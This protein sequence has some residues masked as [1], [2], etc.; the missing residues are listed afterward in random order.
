MAGRISF[1][2]VVPAQAAIQSRKGRRSVTQ[3][4]RLCGDDG[5]CAND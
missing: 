2:F 5:V 1:P 3:D 4:P